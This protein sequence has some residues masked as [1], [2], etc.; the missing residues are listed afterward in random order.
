MFKRI[1]NL[2]DI[3]RYTVEELVN[4]MNKQPD[5]THEDFYRRT[6]GY[7]SPRTPKE[8][9]PAQIVNLTTS[10]P[11]AEYETPEQSLDDTTPR[12]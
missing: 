12:N 11:F 6:W 8:Y 5:E 1:R 9:R 4:P 2:L 3:S 7:D 10:D